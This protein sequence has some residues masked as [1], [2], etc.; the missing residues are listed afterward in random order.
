MRMEG[1][2][3]SFSIDFKHEIISPFV[4]GESSWQFVGYS[5]HF[6]IDVALLSYFIDIVG[7][8]PI[9]ALYI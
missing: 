9:V 1:S 2:L 7:D 5:C 3:F 8:K 6:P 4:V